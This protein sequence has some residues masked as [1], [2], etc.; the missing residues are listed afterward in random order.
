MTSSTASPGARRPRRG[1]PL[2]GLRPRPRRRPVDVPVLA[3]RARL[4]RGR[5]VPRTG[6]RWDDP[7]VDAAARWVFLLAGRLVLQDGGAARDR[8][9][10]DHARGRP[11]APSCATYYLDGLGEFAYRNGLDLSDLRIEAPA[12]PTPA[13][14]RPCAP[15]DPAAPLVPFGGGIDSIVTVELVRAR[16]ADAALFVVGR[17]GRPL[18]RHRAAPP[19]SPACRSCGPSGPSTTQVLRSARARASST[20]TCRSPASSPPSP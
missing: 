13:R 11:S 10:R 3:R 12:S 7:A 5:D 18:R 16:L 9:P 8:P 6:D 4:R 20:A 19:P 2:R 15:T 17:P 14:R 1:L